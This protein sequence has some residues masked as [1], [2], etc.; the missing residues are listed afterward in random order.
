[1]GVIRQRLIVISIAVVLGL[2]GC[3]F[4]P[5]LPDPEEKHAVL[6]RWN[7][8]LQRF[9]SNRAHFCDGHRRDVVATYPAYL[10]AQLDYLLR[11]QVQL[12]TTR[13]TLKTGLEGMLDASAPPTRSLLQ[14]P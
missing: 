10:E 14:N 2:Q 1:M 12:A 4:T 8:C 3:S 7:R 6:E 11:A 5:E 13:A 9:E